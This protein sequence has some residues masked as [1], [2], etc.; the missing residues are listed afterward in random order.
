MKNYRIDFTHNTIIMDYTFAKAA[1]TIGSSAYEE[2]K[3]ILADFPTMTTRVASHREQKTS[4]HNKNLTYTHMTRYMMSFENY[5]ELLSEFE[6]IKEQ[7]CGAKNPYSYVRTW[8]ITTFPDYRQPVC[9][10]TPK[11]S[12]R[13]IEREM[14][15]KRRN[16]A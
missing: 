7:S 15:G 12:F 8:F 1:Q 5:D 14:E 2:L 13:S 3:R 6:I 11:S 16:T 4:H 10:V 9:R